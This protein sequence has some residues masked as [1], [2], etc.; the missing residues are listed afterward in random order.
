MMGRDMIP[1]SRERGLLAGVCLPCEVGRMCM[2]EKEVHC[3]LPPGR[4]N[5]HKL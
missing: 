5:G 4:D 2:K 3:R 1:E